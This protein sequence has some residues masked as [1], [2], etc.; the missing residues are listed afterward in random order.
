MSGDASAFDGSAMRQHVVG[1]ITERTGLGKVAAQ[2]LEIGIYNWSLARADD[3]KVAKNW[4]NR[5]FRCM[6]EAKARSVVANVDPNGYVG[7]TKLLARMRDDREFLPHDVASMQ[8]EHLFPDRWRDILDLK[9]QRDEYITNAKPSAMTD[10]FK[11]GRCKNRQT[12]YVEAQLRSADEPATLF[13]Q[14][15][16]CGLRWRMG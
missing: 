16:V 3:R 5:G 11:C 9:L 6:Y 13:I 2:D 14:C 12:T 4:R 15:C 8:P 1:M 7:N 10:Q